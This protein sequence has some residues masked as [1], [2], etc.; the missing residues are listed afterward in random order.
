VSVRLLGRYDADAVTRM[1]EE[2]GVLD[3]VRA[4]GFQ[5]PRLTLGLIDSPL[6]HV[7]LH[8]D[9]AGGSH[10]L[11]DGCLTEATADTDAFGL[12]GAGR[13][14]PASVI[15]IF[16]AREQDPTARFSSD[17]PRLPLQ[18]HPG[19]GVLRKVFRIGAR[20]A[21]EM[22]KDGLAAYPKFPHD[23]I[24]FFR[25]RLFLFLHGEEQ[26]RLEAMWRDL[27]TLGLR[28]FSLAVSAGAVFDASGSIVCGQPGLQVHPLSDVLL[29]HFNSDAYAAAVAAGYA[30]S[31][32]VHD[33]RALREAIALFDSSTARRPADGHAPSEDLP[34][35]RRLRKA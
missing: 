2:G 27:G 6:T 29:E 21:L 11:F 15:V 35:G 5:R 14:G 28:D 30:S 17:R 33:P 10:L 16:W 26:G 32:Y 12:R 18:D 1:F 3:A 8:A 24:I 22:K 25:S 4:K 34:I 20:I 23:A 7:Q 9:K 13:S 19:L 31:R